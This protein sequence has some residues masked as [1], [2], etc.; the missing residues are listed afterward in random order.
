[1]RQGGA[2]C[3]GTCC[4]SPV[5]HLATPF[6][7]PSTSRHIYYG[8]TD[9][10]TVE[11]YYLCYTIYGLLLFAWNPPPYISSAFCM[12]SPFMVQRLLSFM[13]GACCT[14]AY[15]NYYYLVGYARM[16]FKV[17][18]ALVPH[19]H[20]WFDERVPLNYPP[21]PHLLLAFSGRLNMANACGAEH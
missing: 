9:V 11:R 21:M 15:R 18:Y 14:V 1:V 13:A 3:C 12:P 7:L 5:R 17:A 2:T 20:L 19:K 6:N 8:T 16:H 10:I 4:G